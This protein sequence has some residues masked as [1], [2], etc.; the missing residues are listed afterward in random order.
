MCTLVIDS[1]ITFTDGKK[2]DAVVVMACRR[3]ADEGVIWAQRYVPKGLFR[4]FRTEGTAEEVGKSRDFIT[5][6]LSDA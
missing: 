3:G 1:R 2:W 4:K 5:A 6:A